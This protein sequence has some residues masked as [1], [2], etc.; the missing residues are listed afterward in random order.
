MAGLKLPNYV[1][2]Q[3]AITLAETLVEN[4]YSE[5]D[6]DVI[7]AALANAKAKLTSKS[8]ADIDK[9]EKDLATVVAD[10]PKI[11][12]EGL[13]QAIALLEGKVE[14]QYTIDSWT[15]MSEK[16]V[17]AKEAL[18]TSRIQESIDLMAR[19]LTDAINALVLVDYTKLNEL[20]TLAATKVEA[21][22][23]AES[24]QAFSAA[25]A[26]ANEA[27]TSRVQGDVDAAAA[28]L[29]EAINGLVEVDYELE[30]SASC[31]ASVAASTI[32]LATVLALG[33]GVT[34]KKKE[35]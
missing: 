35:D 23:T 32:V 28:A 29:E 20:L 33:A 34:F 2:L 18:E 16:L 3:E 31:S 26:S 25:Y 4:D 7:S 30:L 24:W 10:T 8:Q 19:E 13:K 22:Y 9:A 5:D 11:D 27:L 1:A 21:D 12:R 15:A 14:A 6:W 17:A